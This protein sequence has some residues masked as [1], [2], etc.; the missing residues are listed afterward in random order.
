MHSTLQ[1]HLRTAWSV[2][3]PLVRSLSFDARGERDLRPADESSLAVVTLQPA[4]PRVDRG[5]SAGGLQLSA[6]TPAGAPAPGGS[7]G[8]AAGSTGCLPTAS[9]LG[10]PVPGKAGYRFEALH[11]GYRPAYCKIYTHRIGHIK[12]VLRWSA[13]ASA[14]LASELEQPGRALVFCYAN[15]LVRCACV[16]KLSSAFCRTWLG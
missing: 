6:A 3:T 4:A 9:M 8:T 7:E 5:A 12:G 2:L 1:A 10:A 15:N 13:R 11:A 14:D 16:G